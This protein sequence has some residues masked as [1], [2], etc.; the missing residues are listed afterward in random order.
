MHTSLIEFLNPPV[1]K[2]HWLRQQQMKNRRQREGCCVD[3][4]HWRSR[5]VLHDLLS[6][7][8]MS[9]VPQQESGRLRKRNLEFWIPPFSL[10]QL[11]THRTAEGLRSNSILCEGSQLAFSASMMSEIPPDWDIRWRTDAT[12][13]S[14]SAFVSLTLYFETDC[15]TVQR[16]SIP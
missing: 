1:K 9:K 7:P 14:V 11:K 15:S 2:R 13:C 8:L 3:L 6:F 5:G 12:Q 4:K 16:P 10:R